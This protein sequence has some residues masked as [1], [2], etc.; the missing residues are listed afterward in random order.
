M[1]Y[2]T[3]TVEK[4]KIW[5]HQSIAF[6]ICLNTDTKGKTVKPEFFTLAHEEAEA[7]ALDLWNETI[8]EIGTNVP[9]NIT[10]MKVARKVFDWCH[11]HMNPES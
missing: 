5:A 3:D 8:G 10:L 2:Q 1:S 11:S 4:T 7:I 9:G 6:A